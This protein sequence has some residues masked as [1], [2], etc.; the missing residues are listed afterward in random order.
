[1]QIFD[2]RKVVLSAIF[3]H[4]ALIYRLR[5]NSVFNKHGCEV[6]SV[7]WCYTDGCCCRYKGHKMKG[8][9]LD[10][11][12]SSR[13]THVLSCSEDGHV[14]CWDLVEVSRCRPPQCC[15]W[16]L[17]VQT[18]GTLSR[19]FSPYTSRALCLWSC[20]WGKQ[21]FSLCPSIH[22]R[23]ACSPPWRAVFRC[24]AQSQRRRRKRRRS[25]DRTSWTSLG[26][27]G[28]SSNVDSTVGWIDNITGLKLF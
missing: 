12:L 22:P 1:M 5:T 21:S 20:R 24:G 9:K 2:L 25:H 4:S 8:Y 3:V 27:C 23:P 18:Y 13:D 19:L 10:C 26:C 7:L 11:C 6:F 14:Y 15:I 28:G 17:T 16:S